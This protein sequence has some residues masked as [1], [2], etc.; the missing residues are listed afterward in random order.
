MEIYQLGIISKDEVVEQISG[1]FSDL[2]LVPLKD[3][4]ETRETDRRRNSVFRPLN[5]MDFS[6][7]ERATHSYVK[8]PGIYPHF[9]S[10]D[11]SN[12]MFKEVLNK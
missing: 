9:C 7:F 5:D 8:M 3:I 11:N 6:N 12:N 10:G 2:D 1:K 4:V